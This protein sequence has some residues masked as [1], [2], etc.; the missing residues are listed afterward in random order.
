EPDGSGGR[1]PSTTEKHPIFFGRVG[2]DVALFGFDLAA[3]DARGNPGWFFV[4][5]EHP[6]E[7]RFGLAAATDNYGKTP[8]SWQALGWD[9]LATNADALSSIDYINLAATLPSN[10][11]APGSI[12][13]HVTG[14]PP[15]RA[16]DL[17]YITLRHPKRFAVHGSVLLP[18]QGGHT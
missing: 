5:Q 4:L 9:H 6:S 3:A 15:G 17:A 14:S 10:P 1:E 7:P 18:Q 13:W 8:S 16:A 11:T 12:G 2:P